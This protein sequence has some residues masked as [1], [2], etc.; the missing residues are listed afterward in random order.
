[1]LALLCL[2]VLLLSQQL[3]CKTCSQLLNS[4]NSSIYSPTLE[5]SYNKCKEEKLNTG[6]NDIT[7]TVIEQ[8]LLVNVNL[9]QFIVTN[10]IDHSDN[11][12]IS[13]TPSMIAYFMYESANSLS[14][15]Q[16]RTLRRSGYQELVISFR[17][18]LHHYYYFMVLRTKVTVKKQNYTQT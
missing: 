8:L 6:C 14:P 10:Q 16:H 2:D 4:S 13:Y 12:I 15:A 5:R 17:T 11:L 9:T 1:M 3:T 18:N 7:H